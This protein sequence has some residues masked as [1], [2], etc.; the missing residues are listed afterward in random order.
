MI[1]N[2]YAG[3]ARATETVLTAQEVLVFSSQVKRMD[4]SNHP[5]WFKGRR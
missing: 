4:V 1:I 3:I 2:I 5:E